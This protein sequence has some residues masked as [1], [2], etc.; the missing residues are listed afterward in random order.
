[1]WWT[2][3]IDGYCERVDPTFWSEPINAITNA[4]F[5][6]AAW[7]VWRRM[8]RMDLPR[9]GVFWARVLIANLAVIGAG[10]FLFHTFAN[11]WS[12]LADVIPIASFVFIYIY[13]ANRFYA[14][15]QPPWTWVTLIFVLPFLWLGTLALLAVGPALGAS[16]TYGAVALIILIY[17]I[18][19]LRG[20]P[21]V[22]VGLIIG[23]GLLCL[24]ITSRAL[25][26]PMCHVL[27]MGTHF[28]WHT[29]N[30]IMLGWM[31]WVFLRHLRDTPADELGP[32]SLGRALAPNRQSG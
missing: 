16:A 2:D 23:A 24:S 25:D 15:L 9:D 18:L 29:L 1:M 8:N 22:G 27:P 6:I 19:L 30:G 10:S 13:V 14:R 17:G 11:G 20:L 3:P 26:D 4:A 5:L 21:R 32:R 28:L 31:I 7:V 12:M